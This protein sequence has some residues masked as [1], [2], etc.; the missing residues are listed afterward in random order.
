[1]PRLQYSAICSADLYTVDAEGAFDW[2]RPGEREHEAINALEAGVGTYLYGRRM[3]ETM[4]VWQDIDLDEEP[5]VVVEFAHLW[6]AADKVVFSRTLT[7][8]HTPKTTLCAQLDV[9]AVR[10]LVASA[11]QDVSIGGPGLA[12]SAMRAGLVDDIH[13]FVHPIIVGGGTPA[14]PERMRA[15]LQLLGARTLP[16]D[17]V[18][19]DYRLR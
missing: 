17:V 15:Q 13:L 9:D 19:L 14:L 3:Y 1:M 12:A 11:D 2:A 18:Q 5:P 8:V 4:R 16:G 7:A 6:R 10:E